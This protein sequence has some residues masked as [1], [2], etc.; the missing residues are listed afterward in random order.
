MARKYDRQMVLDARRLKWL[1]LGGTGIDRLYPLHELN[2]R[3]IITNTPG[4]N[5]EMMAD[6][7][8]CVM[9]MLAW[10]F[11]QL[12]RNQ[13]GAPVGTM[14]RR[15]DGGQGGC[16]GGAGRNRPGNRT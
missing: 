1:H 9:L 5:A 16:G 12:M 10:D 7:V 4:L 14:A 2:P 15:S 6:Y 8:L 3:L 11:P 13:T